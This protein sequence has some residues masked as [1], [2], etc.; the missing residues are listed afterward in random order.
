LKISF[1]TSDGIHGGQLDEGESNPLSL[2][3]ASSNFIVHDRLTA[4]DEKVGSLSLHGEMVPVSRAFK[5]C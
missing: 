5:I 1:V 3:T 2:T 4:I